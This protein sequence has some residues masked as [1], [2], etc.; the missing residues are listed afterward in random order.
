MSEIKIQHLNALLLLRN[1]SVEK[2]GRI[3]IV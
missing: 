3:E 1:A 2:L